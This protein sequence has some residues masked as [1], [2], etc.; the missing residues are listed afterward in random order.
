MLFS[1]TMVY[2]YPLN[3]LYASGCPRMRR[4][5][6]ARRSSSSSSS[7]SLLVDHADEALDHLHLTHHLQTA[8]APSSTARQGG[9]Q[10]QQQGAARSGW[11]GFA[12]SL[13][14]ARNWVRVGHM[15]TRRLFALKRAAEEQSGLTPPHLPKSD[16]PTLSRG[17]SPHNP[18][19]LT[20]ML[21][22]SPGYA[23]YPSTQVALVQMDI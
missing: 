10:R 5:A 14:L 3:Y 13:S 18:G 22:G 11:R 20:V 9:G 21:P 8:P 19:F 2:S 6:A 23:L 17:R 7:S 4:G 15:L 1:A 12:A 16:F